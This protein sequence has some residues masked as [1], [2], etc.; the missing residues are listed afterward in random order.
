MNRVVQTFRIISFNTFEMWKLKCDSVHTWGGQVWGGGDGRRSCT[1]WP[2]RR[3]KCCR[4]HRHPMMLRATR[5][6]DPHQAVAKC[7]R[8][9]RYRLL[10]PHPSI[11]R[12]SPSHSQAGGIFLH[13]FSSCFHSSTPATPS[14]LHS[15]ASPCRAIS[16][17]REY[18]M[19]NDDVEMVS[20]VKASHPPQLQFPG[21]SR[22]EGC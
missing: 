3:T 4:T 19:T 13:R 17:G 20:L 8:W 21:V 12:L 9:D 1:C 10:F 18:P 16:R 6:R 7:Q 14:L 5:S 22:D 11:Y 15:P 2:V